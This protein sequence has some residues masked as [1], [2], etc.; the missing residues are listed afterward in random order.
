MEFPRRSKKHNKLISG[1]VASCLGCAVSAYADEKVSIVPY[2]VNGSEAQI[3]DYPYMG[4]LTLNFLDAQDPRIFTFCGGT[5][6][7]ER[8]VLTAAHCVFAESEGKKTEFQRLEVAFNI[9]TIST[10]ASVAS[11]RHAAQ[12]IYYPDNYN[13][14]SFQNDIAIIKLEKPV[15]SSLVP[16]NSYVKLAGSESYRDSSFPF[17]LIGYGNTAPDIAVAPGETNESD[18]LN[19]VAMSYLE[20][21][22]CENSFTDS[23][24]T[25][26]QFCATGKIMNDLRSGGCQGDSGGPLLFDDAGQLYQAGIVSFGPEICGNPLIEV[27][28]VYTEVADYSDWIASVL[29]GSEAPKQEISGISFDGP[30]S[31]GTLPPVDAGSGGDIEVDSGGG[32]GGSFGG[33]TLLVLGLLGWNRRRAL[34]I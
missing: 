28:S 5:L 18:T 8:Y 33:L 20:T 15:P 11:N 12:A 22:Q 31:D 26:S 19:K 9:Q 32:G 16:A 21:A 23:N 7:N 25:D 3:S 27:Q 13:N 1:I 2:I 14:T 10:D 29:N 30:D 6:L 17:T 4:L 34:N 24:I